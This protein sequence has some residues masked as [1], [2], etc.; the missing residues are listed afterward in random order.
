MGLAACATIHQP[1]VSHSIVIQDA[2]PGLTVLDLAA[3]ILHL[4]A[5]SND[6]HNL[7]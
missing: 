4:N 6:Q 1:V 7:P 3:C 5:K 2:Q